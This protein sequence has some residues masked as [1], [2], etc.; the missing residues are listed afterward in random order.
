M[1]DD[2]FIC[3]HIWFI[4]LYDHNAKSGLNSMSETSLNAK[5]DLLSL[6]SMLDANISLKPLPCNTSRIHTYK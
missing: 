1:P 5:D 4:E 6:R 2:G 3:M